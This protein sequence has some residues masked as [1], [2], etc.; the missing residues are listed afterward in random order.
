MKVRR[1]RIALIVLVPALLFAQ[2]LLFAGSAAAHRFAPSVLGVNDSGGGRVD[3]MWR[4]PSSSSGGPS[5]GPA[6]VFPIR[7]ERLGNPIASVESGYVSER[8]S[9]QCGG[10]GL[11]GDSIAFT[12]I[13]G[14]GRHALVRY[15]GPDG[16]LHTAMM[17]TSAERFR[18]PGE[19]VEGGA[20]GSSH[21]VGAYLVIGV[22]HILLGPDHLLFVL[23]IVLLVRD[24]KKLFITITAFTLAHS[25]TLALAVLD[26][27][28]LPSPP[29]EAAIALSI[30]MLAAESLRQ[31]RDTVTAQKPWLVAF[32]FG[33]LHGMGFAGALAEV[34]LPS[35]QVPAAL[36]LFN[37]GVELGQIAFVL[38]LLLV[39]AALAKLSESWKRRGLL[40]TCYATGCLAA[41]WTIER[42]VAFRGG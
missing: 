34:G 42:V 12:G 13:D 30:V 10:N 18:V 41:F 17:R 38:A 23:C 16:E 14:S 21:S 27:F 28:T 29:V 39:G 40:L 8:Y 11:A 33:L 20:E 4:V 26:I 32:A 24:R 35:N 37:V 31:E 2:L 3:V 25:I 36:V 22:E 9:L 7:C 15:T 5:A 6:P 1:S 19:G